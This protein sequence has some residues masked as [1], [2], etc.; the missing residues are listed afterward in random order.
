M[1]ILQNAING[2]IATL[3]SLRTLE[4]PLQRASELVT[5]ALCNGKK[6][7]CCGNGGSAADAAHFAT[8]FLCRF[9]EDR[10]PYPALCLASEGSLLTAVGNDYSFD[11]VFARQ[12][13]GLAQAGDILIAFT[14]S[15]NSRNILRA[16]EEANRRNIASIAFL[17]RDGGPAKGLATV[18]LLVP[19]KVTARIQE[20]HKLLLHALCETVEQSLPKA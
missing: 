2:A 7:L 20:G 18:E 19:G 10:R 1:M 8:E 14:T 16:L 12:V 3:E 9:M 17:G 5:H 15:G 4:E 13:R 6:L 11:E